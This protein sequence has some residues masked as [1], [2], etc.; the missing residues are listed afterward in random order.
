MLLHN[1]WII[2]TDPTAAAAA[3]AAATAT[4]AAVLL[5]R[6]TTRLSINGYKRTFVEKHHHRLVTYYRN[7]P[8]F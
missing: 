2:S 1:F 3:A 6:S 5:Q 8:V 7:S 4:A